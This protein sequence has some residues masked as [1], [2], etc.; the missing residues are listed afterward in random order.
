MGWQR[1]GLEPRY[2]ITRTDGKPVKPEARYFVLNYD[3][4]DPHATL[5]MQVYAASIRADN[6]HMADDIEGALQRPELAPPQHD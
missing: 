2:N 5:A 3:G 4:S 6:P 1:G